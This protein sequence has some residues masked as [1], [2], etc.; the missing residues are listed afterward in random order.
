MLL[1]LSFPSSSLAIPVFWT[2]DITFH[3]G[4]TIGGSFIFDEDTA[5]FSAINLFTQGG[6]VRG[7]A[8]YSSVLVQAPS[9][10]IRLVP[11]NTLPDLTLQPT[12]TVGWAPRGSLTQFGTSLGL[13]NAGGTL[14]AVGAREETCSNAN[15][16]SVFPG[17]SRLQNG[18]QGVLMGTPLVPEPPSGLLIAIGSSF[19]ASWLTRKSRKERPSA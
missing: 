6:T 19:L 9:F 8:A 14:Q 5:V 16:T 7:P 13:S 10:F 15:C 1:V 4:G 12:L 11:D 3:D 18:F 17:D 2:A